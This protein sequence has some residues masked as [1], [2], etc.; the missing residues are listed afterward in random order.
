MTTTAP[1]SHARFTSG[2]RAAKLSHTPLAAAIT[3]ALFPTVFAHA[4]EAPAAL[5][6]IVVTS[7]RRSESI[8]ETPVNITAIGNNVIDDLQLDSV[9]ELTRWVPG[10][11]MIDQGVWN[12]NRLV[13]RGLNADSITA[14]YG[15]GDGGTVAMYMGETP[16]YVSFKLLDIERVE[17]LIGPQGTLY[18]A[19][20]LA[21]AVRYIPKRP[22]LYEVNGNAHGRM[23]SVA[24]ADDPGF[25]GD[26]AL[27]L[28]LIEGKL[29]L[30]T[31]VGYYDD[32]GFIDYSLLVRTP[33]VSY[34]QPDFTDP[35]AVAANLYR[36]KDANYERTLSSRVSLLYQPFDNLEALLTYAHQDSRTGGRQ[37]TTSPTLGTGRYEGGMRVLEPSERDTDLL[38]LEVT[39]DLGFAELVSS[40]SYAE[41]RNQDTRDMTDLLLFFEYGY[42][43]FPQ[44]VTY[45]PSDAQMDQYAQELRLVSSGDGPF[46]W[47]VGGF[48]NRAEHDSFYREYVPGYPQFAG[49]DRPDANE[50]YVE[51]HTKLSEQAVFGEIGYHFT[52]AWQVTFGGRYFSYEQ[53]L[54]SGT[55]LPLLSG[56][57]T[58]VDPAFRS[59][60]VEQSGSIFKINTSYQFTPDLM[61]Y[62][63]VSE[64]YRRGGFNEVPPCVL[65]IDS[66]QQNVC[67][68]PQEQT[69]K[70]DETR[71]HEIGLRSTWFD[72]RLTVN[73]A[74]YYVKWRDVQVGT[75]TF[76]G[77]E[78]ITGNGAEAES[79]G[80]ELQ[81]Q[82]ALSS[83]LALMGAY[84]YNE[85]VLSR[86]VPG[87]VIDAGG[88][89]DAF[90][91]DRLPGSPEQQGSLML[92]YSLPLHSGYELRADYG[93]TAMSDVY[94]KVGMR[95]KGERLPGYALHQA[96]IGVTKDNWQATLYAEN[97]FDKYAYTAAV[98]DKSYPNDISGLVL[99]RYHH[100]VIRPRQVGLELSMRF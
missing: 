9:E 81:F 95:G 19:G 69:Y 6:E 73:G 44:F 31:V 90:D 10:V 48:Y 64:G 22:D 91:G 99:R 54:L 79:K 86:D 83:N 71:N 13:M 35:N 52:D 56:H 40:S 29:A 59:G 5:E 3:A 96:S 21:G 45:A 77:K 66:A 50:Y 74:V 78:G 25:Q 57:P 14:S 36:R 68:L 38:S 32:P 37:I 93:I 7:T 20:T 24:H 89:Y 92:Q 67:A 100:T 53:D 75:V 60:S 46:K 17:V 97:L 94:T 41:R 27:N 47:L 43:D 85:A 39:A 98:A 34:P 11:T 70:P 15:A 26:F 82:A 1:E 76:Y 87:L 84:T 18:G 12:N 8:Q 72:K 61:L 55:D 58:G 28:P 51:T 4:Q 23:Y 33:G 80:V 88:R 63:T 16:L 30:R 49:I 62:A 2:Q 42:E 65:P